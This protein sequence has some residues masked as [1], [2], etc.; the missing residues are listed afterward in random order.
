[1]YYCISN[2]YQLDINEILFKTGKYL[3]SMDIINHNSR[4]I[5]FNED[6]IQE[7]KEIQLK[8]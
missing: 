4:I 7:K 5:T 3:N 2:I 8:E 6:N 1:M